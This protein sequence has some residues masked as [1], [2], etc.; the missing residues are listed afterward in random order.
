MIHS[1]YK[2]KLFCSRGISIFCFY[3]LYLLFG[4]GIFGCFQEEIPELSE[5]I[6]KICK[7]YRRLKQEQQEL[8]LTWI[9]EILEKKLVA[10][11][12]RYNL[13]KCRKSLS[14]RLNNR[15]SLKDKLVK[16]FFEKK[17]KDHE[18]ECRQLTKV[19]DPLNIGKEELE[20]L[21]KFTEE[22]NYNFDFE[23]RN[24]Y[25]YFSRLE[26]EDDYF[27]NSDLDIMKNSNLQQNS[28]DQSSKSDE[29]DEIV[30]YISP[31]SSYS[32][33][34][35]NAGVPAIIEIED[36]AL[37]HDSL[38]LLVPLN[39]PLNMNYIKMPLPQLIPQP[40]DSQIEYSIVLLENPTAAINVL[41]KEESEPSIKS[42]YSSNSNEVVD[43]KS[44]VSDFSGTFSY[45]ISESELTDFGSFNLYNVLT[46]RNRKRRRRT[47]SILNGLNQQHEKNDMSLEKE[48]QSSGV[49]ELLNSGGLQQPMDPE[50][51]SSDSSEY[52]GSEYETSGDRSYESQ[53]GSYDTDGDYDNEDEMDVSQE[54]EGSYDS[55]TSE[56]QSGSVE[57]TSSTGTE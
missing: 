1:L 49:I 57:Y 39:L 47:E 26:I 13:K 16:F 34:L 11:N 24:N 5:N 23:S 30:D 21:Q 53:S 22:T 8:L 36:L 7:N 33:Y 43:E 46:E 19:S 32:N 37:K 52:S 10:F 6:L 20:E 54:S 40:N 55:G 2:M 3:T 27:S 35:N 28:Q 17:I 45:A 18:E 14:N 42:T 44:D 9:D 29:T 31:Y 48:S 38:L 25:Y 15:L 51:E 12:L 56:D 4:W 41:Y 50:T